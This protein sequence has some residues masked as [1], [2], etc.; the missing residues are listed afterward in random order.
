[1]SDDIYSAYEA[2][3]CDYIQ[4]EN[5]CYAL[6]RKNALLLKAAKAC[7]MALTLSN[8]TDKNHIIVDGNLWRDAMNEL[9]NI[10]HLLFPEEYD[11]DD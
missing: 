4:L 1:M 3:E 2:L 8:A 10:D 6:Q 5:E 11:D 9:H 7:G